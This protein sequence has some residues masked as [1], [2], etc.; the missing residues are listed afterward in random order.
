MARVTVERAA[1]DVLPLK[2]VTLSM[3]PAEAQLVRDL[4]GSTVPAGKIKDLVWDMFG[5]LT[6]I[7]ELH[8]AVHRFPNIEPRS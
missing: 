4:L 8:D 1:P 6:E 3:S 5:A 2:S 7:P